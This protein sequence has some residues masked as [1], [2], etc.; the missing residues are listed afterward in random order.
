[1]KV[2]FTLIAFSEDKLFLLT[3]QET[4]VRRCVDCGSKTW[5]MIMVP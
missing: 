3:V 5:Q 4:A 1:M 2:N